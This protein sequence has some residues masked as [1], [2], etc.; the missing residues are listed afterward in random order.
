[1]HKRQAIRDAVK[2]RLSEVPLRVFGS[3]VYP[4]GQTELPG[5]LVYTRNETILTATMGRPRTQERSLSLVIEIYVRGVDNFDDVLDDI[6]ADVEAAVTE[7][8]T[9]DGIALDTTISSMD[10]NFN[11]GADQPVGAAAIELE[12]IYVT[13]EGNPTGD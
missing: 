10:I 11:D 8:V 6:A 1:M 13:T 7:D 9:W 3:R 2:A 12:V 4:M 5:V